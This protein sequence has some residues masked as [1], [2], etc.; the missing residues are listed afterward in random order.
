MPHVTGRKARMPILPRQ[1]SAALMQRKRRSAHLWPMF[2]PI[3]NSLLGKCLPSIQ[4]THERFSSS[5]LKN[6][7]T[8]TPYINCLGQSLL[9]GM[10]IGIHSTA[11]V[12]GTGV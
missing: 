4:W 5:E 1:V 7:T 8:K 11:L 3:G 10:R 12:A 2:A 9:Q 6:N